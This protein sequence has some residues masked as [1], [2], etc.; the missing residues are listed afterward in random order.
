[1]KITVSNPRGIHI[2]HWGNNL[3]FI[4]IHKEIMLNHHSGSNL[5]YRGSSKLHALT[6]QPL[7]S[8]VK[9]GLM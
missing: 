4:E 1:M 6:P 3:P 5:G 2:I 7:L 9:V 8:A